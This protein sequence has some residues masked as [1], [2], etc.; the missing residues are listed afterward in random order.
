MTSKDKANNIFLEFYSHLVIID[1][2][3]E[4]VVIVELAVKM[5]I[6]H[7]NIVKDE[8]YLYQECYWGRFT[9]SIILPQED[10]PIVACMHLN[11]NPRFG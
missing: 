11:L 7:V 10:V 4:A 8:D 5:A 2:L 1:E 3:Y 9:R 6:V